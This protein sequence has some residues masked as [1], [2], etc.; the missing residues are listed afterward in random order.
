MTPIE[1][2]RSECQKNGISL[3]KLEQTLNY[4][5]GSLAKATN[6][7]FSRMQE[8]A[9]YFGKPLDYFREREGEYYT[10]PDTVEE[11]QRLFE[12]KD[13][14]VLFDAAIDSSPQDLQMATDLLKR[15]KRT[16]PDG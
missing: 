5:N 12:N 13:L 4:G 15:L 14:R 8:I 6:L 9:D 1:I 2:I 11:A 16:N 7:P 10:N 3:A